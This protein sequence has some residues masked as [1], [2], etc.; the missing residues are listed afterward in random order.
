MS[1]NEE[2]MMKKFDAI[3]H[4]SKL[5]FR[6]LQNFYFQFFFVEKIV[7]FEVECCE[8]IFQ[9]CC[10]FATTSISL[11]NVI[12]QFNYALRGSN[13]FAQLFEQ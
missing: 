12:T 6:F 8:Q 1:E 13:V 10:N 5:K 4:I 2:K 3:F 11:W 9:Y 7:L